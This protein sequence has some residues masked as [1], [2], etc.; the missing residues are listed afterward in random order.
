MY[1]HFDKMYAQF[2][3]MYAYFDKMY[4]QYINLS[5]T[6]TRNIKRT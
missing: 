5:K 4:A 2:D 6:L 1:A 3:K